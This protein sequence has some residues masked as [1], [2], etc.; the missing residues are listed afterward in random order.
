MR[1]AASSR[2]PSRAVQPSR[3]TGDCLCCASTQYTRCVGLI[4]SEHERDFPF[5]HQFRALCGVRNPMRNT[6]AQGGIPIAFI[7]SG[8]RIPRTLKAEVLPRRSD[9]V[10]FKPP[11]LIKSTGACP[12]MGLRLFPGLRYAIS[13][14]ISVSS[15]SPGAGAMSRI[16]RENAESIFS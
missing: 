1:I 13:I 10:V 8:P 16:V 9:I 5:P 2:P 12:P 6:P 11:L 7:A 14:P 15:V 4:V 3:L